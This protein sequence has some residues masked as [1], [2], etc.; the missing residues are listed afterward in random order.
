MGPVHR[1]RDGGPAGGDCSDGRDRGIELGISDSSGRVDRQA[2][3]PVFL[4]IRRQRPQ[5]TS[6]ARARSTFRRRSRERHSHNPLCQRDDRALTE[7]PPGSLRQAAID[8]SMEK[9]P[10]LG[11]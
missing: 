4:S 8:I 10:L 2:P 3:R 6:I 5:R 7:S 11:R 1:G 9:P